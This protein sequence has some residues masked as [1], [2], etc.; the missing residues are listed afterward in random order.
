MIAAV[1]FWQPVGQF[2]AVLLALGATEG[3]QSHIL[4]DTDR[5]S[6]SIYS[7]PH[8]DP[9]GADC[10]RT[11]DRVWRLVSG[12]GVVPA[13]IAIVF[14][15]TIP[16]SVSGL[17]GF[18]R[19]RLTEAPKV[20]WVLD[21]KNDTNQAMQIWD[22][23]PERSPDV[24]SC[25]ADSIRLVEISPKLEEPANEEVR[26][27][28]G[29]ATYPGPG[30]PTDD[31][32]PLEPPARDLPVD[33]TGSFTQPQILGPPAKDIPVNPIGAVS[34]TQTMIPGTNDFEDPDPRE[35]SFRDF[36]N[37]FWT[38]GNWTDLLAT[39]LNWMFLDFTFYLLGVN[40]SRIIPSMFST[41]RVQPPFS[42]LVGNEWHT[43]V[44]T[45]IGAI[46]GGAVAIKIM[47]NNS[48]RIIQ[49]WSFLILSILFVIVGALY[50][51]LL[52]TN[53][54]A[55]IVAVYVLCQFFYNAGEFES[56][57]H[58]FEASPV[59]GTNPTVRS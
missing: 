10:A 51:K 18:V 57:R 34:Q 53:A 26:D 9:T 1:F 7:N 2:L 22:Y 27:A 52:N 13:A 39:S 56:S 11:V 19:I 3:F 30:H 12:L 36:I 49:L 23:W 33:Y 16:E 15:L 35:Q 38:E 45:S 43:L 25:E 55:W 37:F 46:L 47:N 31:I 6:C 50:V 21:V 54:A 14:R 8:T 58:V 20:Y 4:K 40:S 29:H 41:P 17:L 59:T 32:T 44:A 24:E 42:F 28:N 5:A 48:R